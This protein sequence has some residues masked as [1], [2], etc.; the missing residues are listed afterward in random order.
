MIQVALEAFIGRH[1]GGWQWFVAVS[2][3]WSVQPRHCSSSRGNMGGEIGDATPPPSVE[4]EL[5]SVNLVI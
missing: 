1:V 4:G 2:T 5:Y 3:K